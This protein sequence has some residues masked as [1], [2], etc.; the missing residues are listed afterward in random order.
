M[1]LS[2]QLSTSTHAR[3]EQVAGGP[4]DPFPPNPF[5]LRFVGHSEVIQFDGLSPNRTSSRTG[6]WPQTRHVGDVGL[7]TGWM[8]SNSTGHRR[9]FRREQQT[10]TTRTY[11]RRFTRAESQV[12]IL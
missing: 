1:D 4:A 3:C 2:A 5:N 9:E 10:V 7:G 12:R 6:D 11:A 8:A